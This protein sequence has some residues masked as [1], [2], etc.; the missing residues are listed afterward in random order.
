MVVVAGP[1][2]LV[3]ITWTATFKFLVMQK[4]WATTSPRPGRSHPARLSQTGPAAGVRRRRNTPHPARE[5]EPM[6]AF[7]KLLVPTDFSPAA[8]RETQASHGRFCDLSI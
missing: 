3:L 6:I 2:R 1:A 7:K 5:G 4:N 8:L